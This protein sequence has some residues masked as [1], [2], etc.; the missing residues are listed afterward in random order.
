MK[1]PPGTQP[2]AK[3]V[4]R[5]KGVKAVQGFG[6]GNQYVLFKLQMPRNISVRQREI[7]RMYEE[8]EE[9]NRTGVRK[10]TPASPTPSELKDTKTDNAAA[11]GTKTDPTANTKTEPS[12][13]SH[14]T[15]DKGEAGESEKGSFIGGVWKKVQEVISPD[16]TKA[17]KK[18][19]E[20][21]A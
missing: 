5:G 19:G 9:F 7:L 11:N 6:R 17:T 3:L 2:D 20:K 21:A 15:V 1:V 14:S 16:G 18:N 8:E 13:P 4:L 10:K 12:G